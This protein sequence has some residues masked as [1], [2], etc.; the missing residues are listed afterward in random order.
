MVVTMVMMVVMGMMMVVVGMGIMMLMV[1]AVL[2]MVG[3]SDHVMVIEM[4]VG[5]IPSQ[6]VWFS[7]RS[8]SSLVDL[9]GWLLVRVQ[10]HCCRCCH[11]PPAGQ[12]SCPWGQSP[13]SMF[14]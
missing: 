10:D 8:K 9:N 12:C 7:I 13:G 6:M 2:A 3:D 14:Y 11:C 4:M 5:M 1:I